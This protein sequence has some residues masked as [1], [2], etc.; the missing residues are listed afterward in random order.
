[1]VGDLSFEPPGELVNTSNSRATAL[2]ISGFLIM[3]VLILEVCLQETY[4][5]FSVLVSSGV[6]YGSFG[7]FVKGPVLEVVDQSQRSRTGRVL[8]RQEL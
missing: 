2:M 8:K 3:L 6:L 4:D 7:L 5:A 1:M